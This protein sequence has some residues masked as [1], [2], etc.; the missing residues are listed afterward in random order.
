MKKT[1]YFILLVIAPVL[2]LDLY[3]NKEFINALVEIKAYHLF[4][5][6]FAGAANAVMDIISNH[7]FKISVFQNLNSKYWDATISGDNKYEPIYRGQKKRKKIFFIPIPVMFTDAWHLFKAMHTLLIISAFYFFT[8]HAY[9][10][11]FCYL[12]Y[13]WGFNLFWYLILRR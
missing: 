3:F 9:F 8:P 4:F 10:I 5:L 13:K 12:F 2:A 7:N 11:V 6:F 1:I